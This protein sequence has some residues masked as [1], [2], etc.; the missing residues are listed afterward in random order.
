VTLLPVSACSR[1]P[2]SWSPGCAARSGRR[3]RTIEA[4][5]PRLGTW[6]RIVARHPDRDRVT[7]VVERVFA[8]LREVDAQMSV[9][10]ADSELSRL[11]RAGSAPHNFQAIPMLILTWLYPGRWWYLSSMKL[12]RCLE[13]GNVIPAS[14]ERPPLMTESVA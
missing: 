10:C 9:H 2:G 1:A 6:V 12:S 14:A 13:S 8:T 11:N 4:G 5:R 3:P 7:R